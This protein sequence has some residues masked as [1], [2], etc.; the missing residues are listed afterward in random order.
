MLSRCAVYP[1]IVNFRSP[2]FYTDCKTLPAQWLA[3]CNHLV[4]WMLETRLSLLF[5]PPIASGRFAVGLSSLSLF[6]QFICLHGQR[7]LDAFI[8]RSLVQFLLCS[9]HLS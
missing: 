4:L 5:P 6:A 7:P 1:L 3:T 8:L 9:V 2:T